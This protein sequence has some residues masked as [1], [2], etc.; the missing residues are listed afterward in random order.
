MKKNRKSV[1]EPLTYT[2]EQEYKLSLI[3]QLTK[4]HA[5][6]INTAAAVKLIEQY[7]NQKINPD[8]NDGSLNTMA[9]LVRVIQSGVMEVKEEDKTKLQQFIAKNKDKK[10]TLVV[11]EKNTPQKVDI[12]DS[13]TNKAN[14]FIAELEGSLDVFQQTKNYNDFDTLRTALKAEDVGGPLAKKIKEWVSTK[15][16]YFNEVVTTDDKEFKAAHKHIPL[17]KMVQILEKWYQDLETHELQ[18]KA[19]RKPRVRKPKPPLQQVKALKYLKNFESDD[20]KLQSVQPQSIVG[21]G[22]LWALNTKTKKLSVFVAADRGG[23]QVRGTSIQNYDVEQS[24][25]KTVGRNLKSLVE[26]VLNGGK[27]TLRRLMDEVKSK[28]TPVKERIN[29]DTILLRTL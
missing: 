8:K 7:S 23:L 18:K 2:N 20:L 16:T 24:E 4:Q 1:A 12:Q 10:P 15:I 5:E 11:V 26:K 6:I 3:K 17:K 19:N 21:A 29:G 28:S 27:I 9:A 25:T 13:I 22:Q 14:E